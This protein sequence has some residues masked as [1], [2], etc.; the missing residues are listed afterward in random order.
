MVEIDPPF[1]KREAHISSHDYDHFIFEIS[2]GFR[3]MTGVEK[4]ETEIEKVRIDIT[5]GKG[6]FG[7]ELLRGVYL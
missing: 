4:R 6:C 1:E 2:F 5:I 3:E 7:V